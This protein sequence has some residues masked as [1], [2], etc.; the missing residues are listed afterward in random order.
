MSDAPWRELRLTG[1]PRGLVAGLS[2]ALMAHGAA[3][4]QEDHLPGQ[5]P[6][7]RQP[8]DTGP[9]PP[10]ARRLV[11]VAWF[12]GADE[13]AVL[14]QLA[15]RWPDAAAAATWCDVPEV[16]WVA[17]SEA[18]FP[19]VGVAPGLVIAPPWNA[20]EG[21]LRI[22]PGEGF[23]TGHHA[24]TLGA[25]RALWALLDDHEHATPSPK[26]SPALRV[27]DVGTGSGVLA[28]AAARRG[29]SA[30]GI[31]IDGDALRNADHNAR[32]NGMQVAFDA[33]PLAAID[34]T[35]DIVL[36]NLY[37][38]VLAACAAELAKVT[39]AHLV[40]AGVLADRE[41]LVT[42][43]FAPWFTALSRAQDGEWVSAV[44]AR[45]AVE[46]P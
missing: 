28:L 21:A 11:L 5:A 20:P 6:P 16:D 33:T 23:G 40:T 4:V 22:E 43:A 10:V 15:R 30:R 41:D 38:E 8:W 19:P 18:A 24:S 32:L 29:C 35:F 36:A 46:A 39:G 14:R 17:S 42:E 44:W 34:G 9:P 3:G 7:P 1:V 12:Q 27:L 45:R 37:A 25:L 31:D 26:P 13:A 2:R